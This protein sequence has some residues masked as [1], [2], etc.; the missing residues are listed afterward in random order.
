[1][2]AG[3]FDAPCPSVRA[4]RL[5]QE[6]AAVLQSGQGGV[7]RRTFQPAFAPPLGHERVDRVCQAVGRT[8]CT[9]AVVTGADPMHCGV[10]GAFRVGRGVGFAPFC[11]AVQR[12][13]G[14]HR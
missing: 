10:L 8:P 12:Q 11:Q 14:H 1:M 2:R 4:E 6:I 7:R 3:W 13:L 5:S 9:N